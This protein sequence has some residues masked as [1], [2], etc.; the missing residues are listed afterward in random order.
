MDL[1]LILVLE[2]FDSFVENKA[3]W[4]ICQQ[5]TKVLSKKE[6]EKTQALT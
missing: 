1:S 6:E 3:H 5:I 4:Q 2:Q